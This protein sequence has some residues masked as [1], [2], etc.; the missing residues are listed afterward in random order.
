MGSP[1]IHDQPGDDDD[2]DNDD[3][4]DDDDDDDSKDGGLTS[5]SLHSS[6]PVVE[7][8]ILVGKSSLGH[9][10]NYSVFLS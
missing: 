6:D 4:D 7:T 9:L 1:L 2:D 8:V 10:H 5:V 3:D